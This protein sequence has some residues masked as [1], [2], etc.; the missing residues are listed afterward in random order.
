MLCFVMDTD[1]NWVKTQWNEP[2][3]RFFMQSVSNYFRDRSEPTDRVLL[4][5]LDAKIPLLWQGTP[6]APTRKFETAQNLKWF[7]E[8]NA[9]PSDRCSRFPCGSDWNI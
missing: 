1:P 3:F 5:R 6:K 9:V 2:A 7:L 8:R 4:A